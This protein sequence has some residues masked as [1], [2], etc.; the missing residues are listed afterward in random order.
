MEI[1]GRDRED[2]VDNDDDGDDKYILY[3]T[4]KNVCN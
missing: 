2:D 3:M 4:I 1:V